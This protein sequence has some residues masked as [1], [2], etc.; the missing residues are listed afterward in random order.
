VLKINLSNSFLV[1]DLGVANKLLGM[2]LKRE[3]K[4]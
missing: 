1:K 3:R 2:R 4:Y